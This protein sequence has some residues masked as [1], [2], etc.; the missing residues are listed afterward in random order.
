MSSRLL[1]PALLGVL[2]AAPTTQPPGP[3]PAGTSC[4]A[5]TAATADDCLRLNHLQVLGTHN[6]YHIAP[7][8]PILASLGDRAA[9]LD[10]THKPV[11]VQLGPLGI[12][13]F[14]F[15]VFADPAGG[16]MPPLQVSAS[17]RDWSPVCLRRR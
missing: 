11:P 13:Q 8:A 1:L 17:R 12:R 7:A 14:E 10:Y 5:M 6:S 2:F 4:Q 15:D 16:G 3:S 9:A